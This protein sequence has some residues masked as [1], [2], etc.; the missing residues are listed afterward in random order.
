MKQFDLEDF[1]KNPSRKVVTRGGR[2]VRIICTDAKGESPVVALVEDNG[3]EHPF[4]YKQDGKWSKRNTSD[5]DL[6]FDTDE[7]RIC[8]SVLYRFFND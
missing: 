3:E 1:K 7:A 2:P 4:S 8:K 6:F 5:V